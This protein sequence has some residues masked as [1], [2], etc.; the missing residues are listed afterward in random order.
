LRGEFAARRGRIL[1][2][3]DARQPLSIRP[4]DGRGLGLTAQHLEMGMAQAFQEAGRQAMTDGGSEE[5]R[6]RR[7]GGLADGIRLIGGEGN[8][9]EPTVLA[10][11]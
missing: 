9:M 11:L 4:D 3:I 8:A 10:G 1:N 7:A 2:V 5:C 6:R